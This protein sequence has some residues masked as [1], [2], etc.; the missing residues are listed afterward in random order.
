MLSQKLFGIVVIM[1]LSLPS[2]AISNHL[3]L[4]QGTILV[5]GMKDDKRHDFNRIVEPTGSP[6]AKVIDT[7]KI[8]FCSDSA[9]RFI[10]CDK[11]LPGA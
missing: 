2:F 10:N 11:W 5:T 3:L 1:M 4:R 8:A 7:V 6:G 9:L